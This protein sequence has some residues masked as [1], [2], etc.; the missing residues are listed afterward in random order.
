MVPTLSDQ[1][2]TVDRLG[3]K[4]FAEALGARLH[5]EYQ[6]SK[7][8]LGRAESFMVHLEGSWGSGKTSLLNLLREDLRRRRPR[9]LV[10]DFN[11]WQHQRVGAPWWLLI[12]AVQRQAVRDWRSPLRILL[13]LAGSMVW[14]AWLARVW[15]LA[16]AAGTAL[17]VAL[18][19]TGGTLGGSDVGRLAATVGSIVGLVAG[20]LGLVRSLSVGTARG[21]EAFIQQTRDPMERLQRRFDWIVWAIG[22]P[23]AVFIDDLD[24]CRADHVVDLLEGIQTILR[25]APVTYV[26]AADRHWLYDS[27]AQVYDRHARDDPGR[28]LGHLFLEKSF[29]LSTSLPRLSAEERDQYWDDLIFGREA[30]EEDIEALERTID[31]EFAGAHSEPEVMGRLD[32]RPE[33]TRVEKRLRREAA[34]RRLAAPE[35]LRHTEHTLSRFAALLEPNP[36]A[37]KRLVNAYGVERAVQILEG[38]SREIDHPREKLAL[39]T[40]VKSRWPLLAE[41]LGDHPDFIE[42]I[43]QG[44]VPAEVEAE[45]ERPYLAR[46]FCDH[47]VRRVVCGDRLDGVQLDARSLKHFVSGPEPEEPVVHG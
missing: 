46:L 30:P 6:R 37:M 11:A 3:R 32:A 14:R 22:R 33:A 31:Q 43:T 20:V 7:R 16:L 39:W 27:Y 28:P 41:Y 17:L 24:R 4:A 25:E 18:I 13:L 34:V 23:I 9:W 38:H 21:A 45:T 8:E 19:A 26:V 47:E 15:I 5:D 42:S 40:I 29:Q 44:V 12:A 35:L 1:P 36:R 2:A 10:V